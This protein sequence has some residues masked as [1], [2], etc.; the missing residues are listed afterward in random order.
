VED[1]EDYH[2]ASD[3]FKTINQQFYINA[4]KSIIMIIETLDEL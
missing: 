4:I 2:K 1:H 3:E